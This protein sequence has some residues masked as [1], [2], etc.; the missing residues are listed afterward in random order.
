MK[1]GCEETPALRQRAAHAL[2]ELLTLPLEI[3][4]KEEKEVTFVNFCL[5]T[6]GVPRKAVF[7]E[8]LLTCHNA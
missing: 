8:D 5:M 4:I 7:L 3:A 1:R 6:T 2:R